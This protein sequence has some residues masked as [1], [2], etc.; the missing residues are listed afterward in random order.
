MRKTP[1]F[2]SLFSGCGGMDL[3]FEQAGFTGLLSCDID[4]LVISVHDANLNGRA[5]VLDLSRVPSAGLAGLRPDVV[6]AGPP[7]QG[8]STLGKRQLADP[9]NSLVVTAV[10]HA[11]ALRPKFVALENVQGAVSGQHAEY[12]Q[13]AVKILS[14]AGYSTETHPIVSANFGVPQIRR[15]VLL[16]AWRD[17]RRSCPAANGSRLTGCSP[18]GRA[19]GSEPR[20]QNTESGHSGI[21]HCAA[22]WPASETL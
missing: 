13:S 2:V 17:K 6:I 16:L 9:R 22:D 20:P 4:P 3:G 14:K 15:R 1:T 7:C 19:R 11:V 10:R 18:G 21:P 8:F 5:A 12:W